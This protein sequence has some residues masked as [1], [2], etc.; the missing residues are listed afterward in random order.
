MSEPVA[1][2]DAQGEAEEKGSELPAPQ[3]AAPAQQP[4]APK[5]KSSFFDD[6]REEVLRDST[7]IP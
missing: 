6:R 5:P 4:E 2:G 3:P 1:R 7:L